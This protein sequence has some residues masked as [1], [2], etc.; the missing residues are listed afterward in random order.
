MIDQQN[1]VEPSTR[2]ALHYNITLSLFCSAS[3]LLYAHSFTLRLRRMHR[4]DT[5]ATAAL[6]SSTDLEDR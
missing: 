2:T 5:R 6:R 1:I 3:L 4:G